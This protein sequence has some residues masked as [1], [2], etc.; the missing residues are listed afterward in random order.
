MDGLVV[1]MDYCICEDMLVLQ[2]G[3]PCVGVEGIFEDI[4]CHIRNF[5]DDVFPG[6][7][8]MYGLVKVG[9]V[10]FDCGCVVGWWSGGDGKEGYR[11][12]KDGDGF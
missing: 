5:V 10:L 4:G 6:A 1:C 12:S 9:V 2:D 7:D 11:N 3:F 8:V